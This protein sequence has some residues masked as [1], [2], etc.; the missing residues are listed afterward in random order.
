MGDADCSPF[1]CPVDE[2]VGKHCCSQICSGHP[3]VLQYKQQLRTSLS[4]N[5]DGVVCG[6]ALLYGNSGFCNT[7]IPHGG[8]S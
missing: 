8:R 4:L 7:A 3:A 5:M 1:T 2:P 6:M